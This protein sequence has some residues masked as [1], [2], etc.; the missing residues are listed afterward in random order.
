MSKLVLATDCRDTRLEYLSHAY[1]ERS[2]SEVPT[3]LRWFYCA[4]LGIALLCMSIISMAHD[5]KEFDGQR[6]KKKYRIPNRIAVSIVLICLSLAESLSS[7]QLVSTTTGLVV[8][9]LMV[10]VYGSTSIYDNFWKCTSQCK[11]RADCPLKKKVVVEALKSG[12]TIKLEELKMNDGEKVVHEVCFMPPSP[13][14]SVILV[15]TSTKHI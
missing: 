14:L 8:Y 15:L 7:L 12:T 13:S 1:I 10:D 5:H 2:E 3:G 11:Y 9:V 6:I 4:G